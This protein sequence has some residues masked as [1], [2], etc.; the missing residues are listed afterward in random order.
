MNGDQ[1][2]EDSGRTNILND[3]TTAEDTVTENQETSK[4]G[5]F[6]SEMDESLYL[7]IVKCL[8]LFHCQ[9]S[10]IVCDEEKDTLANFYKDEKR[11]F[12]IEK[13]T[14]KPKFEIVIENGCVQKF[15]DGCPMLKVNKYHRKTKMTET[16]ILVPKEKVPLVLRRLHNINVGGRIQGC[17]PTGRDKLI[18]DFNNEHYFHGIRKCVI[19]FLKNCS[20]CQKTVSLPHIKAPPIP[21]R[22]Y[23]PHQRLQ[24]DLIQM[25]SKRKAHM[26]LNPWRFSYILSVKCCFSKYGWLFPLRNKK[27]SGVYLAMK[28][29]CE[30]EGFPEIMQSDNG[31]EFVGK[32]VKEFFKSHEVRI[33]HGRPRHPQS[34]GQ[35]ENLNKTVKN[36][37]KRLLC[38]LDKEQQGKIWPLL[39]PGIATTYNNSYHHT[40][41]DIPFRLYHNR[42]PNQLKHYV[43]PDDYDWCLQTGT[44]ND[45]RKKDKE[46]N[47]IGNSDECYEGDDDFDESNDSDDEDIPEEEIPPIAPE[48]EMM[49]L[50]DLLQSCASAS[51]SS[52]FLSQKRDHEIDSHE[53]DDVDERTVDDF[54]TINFQASLYSLAKNA[55]WLRYTA[56]ESTE[57]T[58][59]ANFKQALGPFKKSIFKIGQRVLFRNPD[60]NKY[61]FKTFSF[62]K[63]NLIGTVKEA[64]GHTYKV[65]VQEGETKVVKSVFKGEMV[66]LADGDENIPDEEVNDGNVMNLTKVL[67]NVTD[68]AAR[69]R[70]AIYNHPD[71]L[72]NNKKLDVCSL[73]SRYF[74]ALDNE[75][76]ATLSSDNELTDQLSLQSDKIIEDL[77]KRG[78]GFFMYGAWAWENARRNVLPSH[79]IEFVKVHHPSFMVDHSCIDCFQ[80]SDSCSHECCY[81]K[82]K[83]FAERTG[84]QVV[85]KKAKKTAKPTHDEAE[86][87]Q[88]DESNQQPELNST[89]RKRDGSPESKNKKKKPQPTKKSRPTKNSQPTKPA[90]KALNSIKNVDKK[91]GPVRL[92]STLTVPLSNNTLSKNAPLANFITNQ[93]PTH[94]VLPNIV[95]GKDTSNSEDQ[96][97]Q[98]TEPT[99]SPGP[100]MYIPS[101][102]FVESEINGATNNAT[103]KMYDHDYCVNTDGKGT[104]NSKDYQTTEPT[105][106][107]G[108]AM[109][110][111]SKDFVESEING[112]TNNAT[113]KMYDH[114]YCVNTDGKDTSNS[115]DCQTT[116]LTLPAPALSIPSKGFS[117]AA[118]E[119]NSKI[120]SNP[121]VMT[122]HSGVIEAKFDGK[123]WSDDSY[124]TDDDDS[125]DLP[126]TSDVLN[127]NCDDFWKT[128]ESNEICRVK[129]LDLPD[130]SR[131]SLLTTEDKAKIMLTDLF[132]FEFARDCLAQ[133]ASV[134]DEEFGRLKTKKW[135]PTNLNRLDVSC[136]EDYMSE[137]HLKQFKEMVGS[138]WSH[139]SLC[140]KCHRKVSEPIECDM[141]YKQFHKTC[142][143]AEKNCLFCKSIFELEE[144]DRLEYEQKENE[145]LER[146]KNWDVIESHL[147]RFLKDGT[148]LGWVNDSADESKNVLL[149]AVGSKRGGHYGKR[150]DEILASYPAFK[151]MFDAS[152]DSKNEIDQNGLIVA[153]LMKHF[154]LGIADK[155]NCRL[156][157]VKMMVINSLLKGVK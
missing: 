72:R 86:Q 58:I 149:H 117:C 151:E 15:E 69:A 18:K 43:V 99:R 52:G 64:S 152:D 34:Q 87:E 5:P 29:L 129:M 131:T 10:G 132:N 82:A 109:Y 21:I 157:Y 63:L 104:S 110:I 115:K 153:F 102:D 100:A 70:E 103:E 134:G 120:T 13:N 140:D 68:V 144:K 8:S 9:D 35:V 98:T 22:T 154:Q 4:H 36:H 112:A 60:L 41:E 96:Q 123:N 80:G 145:K 28:F 55:E 44:K 32:I 156:S 75:L 119:R 11:N 143:G 38:E 137:E 40:I 47:D 33:K 17:R 65:E 84:L 1:E 85:K 31:K 124:S 125:N 77:R 19:E 67:N 111:P 46:D 26:I 128:S 49:S 91:K 135:L 76:S 61:T 54:G 12:F 88:E 83:D 16:K 62:D 127:G 6:K 51:L 45:K 121:E 2:I 106:S 130:E 89:K 138:T 27:I 78:F 146:S 73:M 66:P 30:K 56:L 122:Y 53:I 101:K 148:L 90:K 24:M 23:F 97:H 105:R 50:N 79:L 114:D 14:K 57:Y 133:N 118:T 3:S 147:C 113:E 81:F 116:E 93:R 136:L 71:S 20:T 107:S 37:L 25:A 48:E 42:E 94:F 108:P 92:A 59:H 95:D 142:F 74:L 150:V 141:C 139:K 155:N 7:K 126:T 39:L